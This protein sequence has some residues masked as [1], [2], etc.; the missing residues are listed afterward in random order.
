M[1]QRAIATNVTLTTEV[2]EPKPLYVT[3]DEEQLYGLVSNLIVNAIQYTPPGGQ[4]TVILDT[5]DR[6][7]LIQVKDTGVGIAPEELQAIFERFYRVNSD[8]SRHTGGSGLGL[9]IAD[10]INQA[11]GGSI[12]VQSELGFGSTFTIQ[13][14]LRST[15][16]Q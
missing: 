4:V 8:R 2:Q 15:V 11:H 10:A 1:R 3:G 13:L 14:P 16:K 5:S 9:P 12:Q 7:A 6:H